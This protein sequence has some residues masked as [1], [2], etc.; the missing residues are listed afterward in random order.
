MVVQDLQ[1]D[2]GGLFLL[3]CAVLQFDFEFQGVDG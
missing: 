3:G 1:D 2:L